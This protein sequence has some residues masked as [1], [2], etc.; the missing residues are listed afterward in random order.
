[1]KPTLSSGFDLDCVAEVGELPDEVLRELGPIG[2]LEVLCSEVDVVEA[3]LEHVVGG[4]EDRGGNG[5]DG[6]FRS[7][8]GPEAE[9]LGLQVAAAHPDRGPRRLDER[10][11]EP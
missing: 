10:G 1:M 4:G 2:A 11:L 9:E 6:L 8:P 7:S 3:A 5:E